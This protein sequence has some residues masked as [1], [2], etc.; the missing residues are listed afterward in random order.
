MIISQSLYD[1]PNIRCIPAIASFSSKGEIKPLYATVNGSQL[2]IESYTIHIPSDGQNWIHFIC[3]V[4]DQE[5][6]KEITLQYSI[7]EHAWFVNAKY[8][9]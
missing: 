9:R 7:T 2:K 5:I 8:F 6:R 1:S 3:S 4:I